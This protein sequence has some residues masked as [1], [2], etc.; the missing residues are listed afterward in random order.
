[1]RSCL[2]TSIEQGGGSG[3]GW[4]GRGGGVALSVL[5]QRYIRP[6]RTLGWGEGVTLRRGGEDDIHLRSNF[7]MYYYCAEEGEELESLHGELTFV[8]V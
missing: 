6:L 1:L 8:I 2:Y 5:Y 3:S 4:R 7:Y